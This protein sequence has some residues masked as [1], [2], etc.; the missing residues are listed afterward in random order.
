MTFYKKIRD[1]LDGWKIEV[2]STVAK[3]TLAKSI[4]RNMG[5]FHMQLQQL[6][7]RI[8]TELDKAITSRVW[9]SN[10]SNTRKLFLNWNVL[11]RPKEDGGVS[12][13]RTEDMNRALLAKLGWRL[14]NCREE[15]WCKHMA[16]N[17][18]KLD[19]LQSALRWKSIMVEERGSG[20]TGGWMNSLC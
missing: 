3:L 20:L 11:C 13:R 12:L 8:H 1:K 18:L 4:L 19:L 14:L 2:L 16:R 10:A 6:L 15:T 9:G 7:R 5:T 17:I